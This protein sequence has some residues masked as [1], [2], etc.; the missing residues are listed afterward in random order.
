M[1]LASLAICTFTLFVSV[2]VI[3]SPSGPYRVMAYDSDGKKLPENYQFPGSKVVFE[4][5]PLIAQDKSAISKAVKYL[6]DQYP[7]AIIKIVDF[8]TQ[9]EMVDDTLSKC[10]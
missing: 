4:E 5:A 10:K 8:K 3:A 1:K 7:D 6:C 2:N 9:E